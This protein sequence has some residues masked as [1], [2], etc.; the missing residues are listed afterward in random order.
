MIL[1]DHEGKYPLLYASG[2]R[3]HHGFR[4]SLVQM[5]TLRDQKALA[6]IED[7]VEQF[8]PKL[9]EE[10]TEKIYNANFM[11]GHLYGVPAAYYYGGTGG[12]IYR[13]DL[14]VKYGAAAPT[15]EGGWPSLEP[16]LEAILKNETTVIPFGNVTTQ[17]MTGYSRNRHGWGGRA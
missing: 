1:D 3:F 6:P 11:L 7:L 2:A 5:T 8:G 14:R 15:S 12:V 17:S 16:F 13:E 10:I 4:R 9:K